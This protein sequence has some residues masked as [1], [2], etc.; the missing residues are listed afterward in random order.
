MKTSCSI[1]GCVRGGKIK[2]SMCPM[3]YQRWYHHGDPL[4]VLKPGIQPGWWESRQKSAPSRGAA[5]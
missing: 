5:S 3:H 1:E 2:R 4:V